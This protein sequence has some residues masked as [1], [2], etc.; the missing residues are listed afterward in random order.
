MRTV[1]S[2]RMRNECAIV[3]VGNTAYS[4]GTE[5]STLD[6]HLEASM[7]ALVDAGLEPRDIDAVMP[8]EMAGRVAEEFIVNLGLRDLAFTS[9]IRSG[10]ASL[11]SAIQSVCLAIA[12]GVAT[13]VLVPW[14]RRGYTEQRVSTRTTVASPVLDTVDEFERPYGNFVA[15]QWFAHGRNATCTSS[16]RR[17]SSSAR[18]R[19][20]AAATRTSIPRR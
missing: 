16:G 4:R 17:A 7:L 1:V 12:S 11:G 15:A 8:Q 9:T 10:G 3:G 2:I 19:S 18:S 5:R 20:P 6:L 13:C 14:G